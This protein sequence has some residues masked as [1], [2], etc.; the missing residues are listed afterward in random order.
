MKI[1]EE[2]PFEFRINTQYCLVKRTDQK[3]VRHPNAEI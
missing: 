1:Q 2:F 3:L